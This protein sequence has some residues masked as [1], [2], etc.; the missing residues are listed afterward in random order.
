M[1]LEYLVGEDFQQVLKRK[2]FGGGFLVANHVKAKFFRGI[3]F[4][5]QLSITPAWNNTSAYSAWGSAGIAMPVYK[6]LSFSVSTRSRYS[7]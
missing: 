2:A 4:T 6:R 1:V 3:V 5:E 7:G